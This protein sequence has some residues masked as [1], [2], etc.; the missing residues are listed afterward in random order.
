M[1]VDDPTGEVTDLLTLLIRNRC[2]N[3]GK[4]ESGEE[5]C[6]AGQGGRDRQEGD[7][8]ADWSPE[9]QRVVAG[10]LTGGQRRQSGQKLR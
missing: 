4:I 10:R 9:S 1:S 5:K 6:G 7:E 8:C 2:V 3:D